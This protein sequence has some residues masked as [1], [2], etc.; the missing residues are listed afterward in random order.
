MMQEGVYEGDDQVDLAILEHYFKTR[1][2]QCM[3]DSAPF[4]INNEARRIE[5]Q[6][7]VI[8]LD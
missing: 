5:D 2:P 3:Q 8:K 1:D 7:R 4:E 6:Q